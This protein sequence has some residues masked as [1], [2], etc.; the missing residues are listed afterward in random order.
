MI[1]KVLTDRSIGPVHIN[2]L[3]WFLKERT[4]GERR[5]KRM[6]AT[7][8]TLQRG[9]TTEARRETALGGDGMG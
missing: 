4:R 1:P 7:P 9:I 2:G 5:S 3:A 6:E 8:S